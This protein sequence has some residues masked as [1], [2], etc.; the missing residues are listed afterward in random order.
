MRI[1]FGNNKSGTVNVNTPST[2][3][4]SDFCLEMVK[5]LFQGLSSLARTIAFHLRFIEQVDGFASLVPPSELSQLGEIVKLCRGLPSVIVACGVLRRSSSTYKMKSKFLKLFA[6]YDKKFP[7]SSS[8]LWTYHGFSSIQL[9]QCFVYCALFPKGHRFEKH[10]LVLL[11][12]A[13]GF[14]Q[15]ARGMGMEDLGFAYFNEL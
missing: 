7:I 3:T 1:A 12:M 11:W 4:M 15:P 2:A 9:K 8:L 10:K 5:K 14:L 13:E 6:S